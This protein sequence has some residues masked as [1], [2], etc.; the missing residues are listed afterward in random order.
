VH[1]FALDGAPAQRIVL[2]DW[3]DHGSVLRIDGE[4]T[5]LRGLTLG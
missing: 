4:S 5:G 1:D 3:Y 2:G